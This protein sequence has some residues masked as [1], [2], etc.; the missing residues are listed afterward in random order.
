M[1]DI[2]EI[3]EGLLDGGFDISTDDINP[4]ISILQKYKHDLLA[5][6]GSRI[7]ADQ[8]FDA[9]DEFVSND[10]AMKKLGFKEAP[11]TVVFKQPVIIIGKDYGT[12]MIAIHLTDKYLIEYSAGG[13]N[14]TYDTVVF[15]GSKYV[16]SSAWCTTWDK[17]YMQRINKVW[18]MPIKLAKKIKDTLR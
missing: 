13:D 8:D 12:P 11:R 9:L 10:T 6:V 14:V 4:I 18:Q 17:D 16:D 5:L 2:S 15:S 7:I 3:L 1:K